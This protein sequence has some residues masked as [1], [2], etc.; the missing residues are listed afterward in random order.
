M[1]KKILCYKSFDVNGIYFK[2][3]VSYEL[4]H[5]IENEHSSSIFM[6]NHPNVIDQ[7]VPVLENDFIDKFNYVV[8]KVKLTHEF[9]EVEIYLE[10]GLKRKEILKYRRDME[11]PNWHYYEKEDGKIIH[12]RKDKLIMVEEL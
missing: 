5:V 10:G 8:E 6:F 11:K 1:L 4:A 7:F 2:S 9:K 12:I 3:G